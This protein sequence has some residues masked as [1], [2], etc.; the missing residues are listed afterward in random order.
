MQ[1]LS[2]LD[3][4]NNPPETRLY[5]KGLRDYLQVDLLASFPSMGI[6]ARVNIATKAMCVSRNRRDSKTPQ[7][8]CMTRYLS[9][10]EGPANQAVQNGG[11]LNFARNLHL[12][13]RF[14]FRV[15][16][17]AVTVHAGLSELSRK[18]RPGRTTRT[19]VPV[20][21]Q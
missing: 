15:P 20:P 13:T 18:T 11:L 5:C 3:D 10:H 9:S 21:K 7:L 2:F 12:S 16:Q 6:Q 1:Y 8:T 14:G 19:G 17:G 4:A